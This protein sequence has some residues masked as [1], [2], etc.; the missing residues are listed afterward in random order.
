MRSQTIIRRLRVQRPEA[1]VYL[2]RRRRAVQHNTVPFVMCT[3]TV[4]H[5]LQGNKRLHSAIGRR[6]QTYACAAIL[7]GEEEISQRPPPDQDQMD[8]SVA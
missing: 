4:V 5:H 8:P 6:R 2:W 7:A 1:T 3:A